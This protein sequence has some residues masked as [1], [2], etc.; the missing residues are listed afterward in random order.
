[1]PPRWPPRPVEVSEGLT[2]ELAIVPVTSIALIT[3]TTIKVG[4]V[5]DLESPPGLFADALACQVDAEGIAER[6][7]RSFM[8][9]ALADYV[10]L[11]KEG[12]KLQEADWTKVRGLEFREAMGERDELVGKLSF[13]EV[14]IDEEGFSELVSMCWPPMLLLVAD[15]RPLAVPNPTRR[16]SAAREDRWVR[17]PFSPQRRRIADQ[18]R[19]SR[20]RMALSEQNLELLP[21]YEQRIEVLK[22]LK[23]IDENQTVLLKGRVACE[24]NGSLPRFQHSAEHSRL[25][26]NSA[27]ELVLTELILENTFAAYEPE[28]VV[29]LLSCFIFQEKTDVEPLL[30]P[31]LEEVSFLPGLHHHRRAPLTSSL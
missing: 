2:Y 17:D 29:A 6:H 14:D 30:T 15:S 31:K 5:L 26:I 8:E 22:G 9:N 23:F 12:L 11:S 25:Q 18:S 13:L 24:V 27:N 3:S 20:L 1:M 7:R 21:D 19:P 16:A 28:E 10:N 4:L